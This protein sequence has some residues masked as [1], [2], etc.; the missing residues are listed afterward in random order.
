MLLPANHI[1]V[2]VNLDQ[3]D[4]AQIGGMSLQIGHRY[5]ENERE[6]SPAICRIERGMPGFKKGLYLLCHYNL[7]D[8][9]SPRLLYESEGL[10]Y[11][12]T[13]VDDSLFAI[14]K[15]DGSLQ[16]ICGNI[17]AERIPKATKM[18][19]LDIPEE[20]LEYY[21]NKVVLSNDAGELKKGQIVL[22]EKWADYE[23]CYTWEN[24]QKRVIKI[25]HEDICGIE[26]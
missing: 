21:H 2:S 13:L 1:L 23:I 17:L 14:I 8:T 5:N 20:H 10:H 6:S 25:L 3:L 4:T 11:F 16:P 12:S 26:N 15:D 7:F 9:E 22:T 18:F 24:Q 19:G